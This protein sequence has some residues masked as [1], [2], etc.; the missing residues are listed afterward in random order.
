MIRTFMPDPTPRTIAFVLT[1]LSREQGISLDD[2]PYIEN[3]PHF[4]RVF[5]RSLNM[6]QE[7]GLVRHVTHTYWCEWF[8]V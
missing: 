2:I 1:F 3:A 4:R 6:A 5:L 7:S 8:L